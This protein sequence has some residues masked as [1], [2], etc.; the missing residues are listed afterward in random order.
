MK[1]KTI[2]LILAVLAFVAFVSNS[3]A[4][5]STPADR[6]ALAECLSEESLNKP[7]KVEWFP[8]KEFVDDKGIVVARIRL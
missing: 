6:K 5:P 2:I 1:L 3:F 4:V 8:K 7:L